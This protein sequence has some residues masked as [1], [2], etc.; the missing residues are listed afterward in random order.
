MSKKQEA[1]IC[2]KMPRRNVLYSSSSHVSLN[3]PTQVQV[4]IC[5]GVWRI[6]H[7][8]LCVLVVFVCLLPRIRI[9]YL[10]G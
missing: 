7:E 2:P 6:G 1:R 9:F 8:G 10:L 4:R 3:V 5:A